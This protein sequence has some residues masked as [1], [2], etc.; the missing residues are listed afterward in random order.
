MVK[1]ELI[2]KIKQQLLEGK[3]IEA[4]RLTLAISGDYINDIEDALKEA[5][6][7]SELKLPTFKPLPQ[8]K[9]IAI[10][11][12]T[13]KRLTIISLLLFII[14]FTVSFILHYTT[15][16]DLER[17]RSEIPS[18]LEEGQIKLFGYIIKEGTQCDAIS[19]SLLL[20]KVGIAITTL[21]SLYLLYVLAKKS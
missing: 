14:L 3:P 11:K 21:I 13:S 1:K 20:L 6:K 17:C 9:P 19:I 10:K 4:I 7:K 12:P 2:S 15:S 18:I 8:Q 16:K 5:L